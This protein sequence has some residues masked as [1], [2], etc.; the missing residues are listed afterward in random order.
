MIAEV[1]LMICT[2]AKKKIKQRTR[3][4]KRRSGK[5]ELQ[6]SAEEAGKTVLNNAV[7]YSEFGARERK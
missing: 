7:N 2:E 5:R 3:I 6:A 4:N 1:D